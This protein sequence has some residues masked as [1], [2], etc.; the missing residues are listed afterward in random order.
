MKK[1]VDLVSKS[2]YTDGYSYHENVLPKYHG[3]LKGYEVSVLVSPYS[4]DP[5]TITPTI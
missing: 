2:A 3:R 5:I 4:M 1:I